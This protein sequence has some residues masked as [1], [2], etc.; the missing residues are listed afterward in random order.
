[1][2]AGTSTVQT[3]TAN[4]T[5]PPLAAV[6]FVSAQ[7]GWV[8]GAGRILA[9][10]DGGQTW[11]TQ[12]SG[13]ARLYQVDF[14][15][16]TRG[17]AVGLNGVLATTDGGQVWT[18]LP[19]P[20]TPIRSVHFVTPDLGYA[21]AGGSVVQL[22][23]GILA[24]TATGA[25][26]LLMTADGGRSWQSVPG[27]PASVQTVC[28]SS[29]SDGFLGTPGR[30]W[31]SVDGGQHWTVSFTEPRPATAAATGEPGDTAVIECAGDTAAW[32]LFLGD[33]AALG[34]AP[35]LGYATQDARDWHV[36]FEEEYTESALLPSVHAPQGPGS[37]PGPFSAISPDSAAF[38]GWVPPQGFGAAPLEMVTG[39]GAGRSMVGDVGGVTQA[40]GAA[41]VSATQGWVIGTD[42]TSPGKQGDYAIEAT[43]DGGRTWTRQYTAG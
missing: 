4:V 39:G 41:F 3:G 15:S 32:A 17:W 29:P 5:V 34:H 23:G 33:G 2:G 14:I 12:Y 10:S 6:Q 16:A 20:C 40:Y 27:A 31:R 13:P 43:S 25:G 28:F 37:Y 11:Q 35:Y 19:E 9:T 24:T 8:A 21:V 42:Q 22:D 26:A 36:L 1:M 38:I 30:I 18:S 7:Q